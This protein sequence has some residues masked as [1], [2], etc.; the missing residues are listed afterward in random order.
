MDDGA[1]LRVHGVGDDEDRA[2]VV[3]DAGGAFLAALHHHAHAHGRHVEFLHQLHH[4]AHGAAV[5]GKVV[6]DQRL[7]AGAHGALG[8]RH[9]LHLA[10]RAGDVVDGDHGALKGLVVA[11]GDDQRH[12][13][14]ARHHQRKGDALGLHRQHEVG[15]GGVIG[16]GHDGAQHLQRVGLGEYVLNVEEV[17]GQ[18]AAGVAELAAQRIDVVQRAL[19]RHLGQE[20]NAARCA[21]HGLDLA[22]SE[23]AVDLAQQ[24]DVLGNGGLGRVEHAAEVAER[25]N[26]VGRCG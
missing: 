26:M 25:K 14:R 5:L 23:L 2:D 6:H 15:R 8:Q 1:L 20:A 11:A 22:Q 13:Q 17:A 16:R 18:N 4:A 19:L 12:A 9:G 3:I 21:R 7:L 10:A 24:L